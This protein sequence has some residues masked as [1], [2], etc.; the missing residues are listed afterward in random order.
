MVTFT[1][2]ILNE[3]LHFL[4]SDLLKY[5]LDLVTLNYMLLIMAYIVYDFIFVG[6]TIVFDRV[7]RLWLVRAF[8]TYGHVLVLLSRSLARPAAE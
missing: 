1:E 3:K 7:G 8:H 5:I 6:G 2:D 4:C